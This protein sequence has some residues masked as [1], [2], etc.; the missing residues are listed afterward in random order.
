MHLNKASL[1]CQTMRTMPWAKSIYFFV[2]FARLRWSLET[3][4]WRISPLVSIESAMLHL[5]RIE[6]RT[7]AAFTLRHS[8]IIPKRTGYILQFP[9][10]SNCGTKKDEILFFFQNT[11]L[12]LENLNLPVGEKIS[13][14][15]IQSKNS[16]KNISSSNLQKN[17]NSS[18]WVWKTFL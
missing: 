13:H 8:N 14:A 5:W 9:K 1:I 10:L 7:S 12:L 2:T 3:K 11:F 16:R 15:P 4:E 17:K 18:A 6:A